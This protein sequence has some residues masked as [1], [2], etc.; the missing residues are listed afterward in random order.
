MCPIFPAVCGQGQVLPPSLARGGCVWPSL[1][2]HFSI[3]GELCWKCLHLFTCW[4]GT[5]PMGPQMGIISVLAQHAAPSPLKQDIALSFQGR[6]WGEL[7]SECK[8]PGVKPCGMLHP[9][10]NTEPSFAL[11]ETCC[12]LVEGESGFRMGSGVLEF[13]LGVTAAGDFGVRGASAA[14]NLYVFY[15]WSHVTDRIMKLQRKCVI[16]NFALII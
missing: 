4:R 16:F 2:T 6:E 9:S 13:L 14:F 3:T 10:P 8:S 5:N 15:C 12:T 11:E 1:H 7:H